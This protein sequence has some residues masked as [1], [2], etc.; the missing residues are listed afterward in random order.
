MAEKSS[1][2]PP[3]PEGYVT[4]AQ[5]RLRLGVGSKAT[6]VK[7]VRDRGILTYDDPRDGRRR[8]LRA[9][10]VDRLAEQLQPRPRTNQEPTESFRAA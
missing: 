6:M 2:S 5:A 9:E 4:M 1:T 8:L 10:D 3:V 7:I